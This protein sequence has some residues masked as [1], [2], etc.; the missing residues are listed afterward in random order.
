M[1]DVT[2][3]ISQ[4]ITPDQEP[5]E[6]RC[7]ER[8]S[9]YVAYAIVFLTFTISIIMP[10][11]FRYETTYAAP[12]AAYAIQMLAGNV[13]AKIAG[14]SGYWADALKI[15]AS[16]PAPSALLSIFLLLTNVP[17]EYAMFNPI[18]ALADISYFVLARRLLR[19]TA[20]RH[21]LLLAAVYY[22]Y[23]TF[24]GFRYGISNV[25]R[26]TFGE[27][28][29][30]FFLLVYMLQFSAP[31]G[32]G[33]LVALLLLALTTGESYYTSTLA[34]MLLCLFMTVIPFVTARS[35]RQVQPLRTLPIMILATLLFVYNTYANSFLPLV[36]S[37]PF[38]ENAFNR[39]LTILGIAQAPAWSSSEMLHIDLLTRVTAIWA[40]NATTYSSILA[41]LYVLL[42]FRHRRLGTNTVIWSFSLAVFLANLSDFAYL[43]VLVTSPIR[44][45]VLYGLI[46]LLFV[47]GRRT[48]EADHQERAVLLA[49]P[50]VLRRSIVLAIVLI[51]VLVGAS[52]AM[53]FA[54]NY[55]LGKPYAYQRVEPLANFLITHSSSRDPIT[56]AG[57]AYYT[58]NIFFIA[59][60]E[61]KLGNV[62]TRPLG[63]D[64]VT[65]YNSLRA[66]ETSGFL[67]GMRDS[68][69][70]C[71]MLVPGAGALWGD[72]WGYAVELPSTGPLD[73]SLAILYAGPA[74]LFCDIIS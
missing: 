9:R 23:V 21:Y 13:S 39:V 38:V 10:V 74:Q 47:L 52:G 63:I 31:P 68:N 30:N 51:M 71:L 41:V 48:D 65:L 46:V 12:P 62:A 6:S 28:L 43:F 45:L 40:V 16:Y 20:N 54:W 42:V 27:M 14:P 7:L 3:P 24:Y 60:R 34:I 17:R 8:I 15:E 33:W 72:E 4:R 70:R 44:L 69:L 22:A 73:A 50:L 57:D 67:A 11:V 55:G 36:A 58:A 61:D 32:R 29:F 2:E 35:V 25:S 66:N 19:G 49:K 5:S 1:C 37:G 53:R 18:A 64:V 26:G 59:A 56:L